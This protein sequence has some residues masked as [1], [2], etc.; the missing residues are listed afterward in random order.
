VAKLVAREIYIM[1]KLTEQAQN[2]FT[3]KLH[4]I[5]LEGEPETFK[6]IFLVMDYGQKDL[7][8]LLD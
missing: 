4:D 5:V 6:S 8:S 1:R 3:I 2:I 7:R